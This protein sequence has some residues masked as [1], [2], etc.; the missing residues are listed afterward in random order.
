MRMGRK[1]AVKKQDLPQIFERYLKNECSEEEVRF[2]LE[3]FREEKDS[4]VLKQL[5]E[6]AYATPLSLEEDV[7]TAAVERSKRV[8]LERISQS[9]ETVIRPM[10]RKWWLRIAVAASL[11][12]GSITLYLNR[13][14]IYNKVN[15]VRYAHVITIKGQRKTIDLP[16]GTRIWLSPS[17]SFTYPDDFRGKTREVNLQGEAFFDV[18]KDKAHPFIVHSG[19]LDTKV[20][21]TTFNIQAYTGAKHIAVVLLTG[22]VAIT[23]KQAGQLNLLPNQQAVFNT[24]TKSLSK[25]DY[26]KAKQML[27]RRDGNYHYEGT[28]VLEVIADIQRDYNIQIDLRGD[29]SNCTFYGSRNPGDDPYKFLRKVCLIINAQIKQ[30]GNTIIIT[31]RGC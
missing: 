5:I 16:D 17:S 18:S 24:T 13:E 30:D 20:L 22:K 19:Q 29:F 14:A 2:L 9:Q 7:D 31:G 23:T 28:P 21:G 4:P 25:N 11:L 26:P 8:L 10:Y 6:A 12:V 3:H 27:D 15:P 1:K